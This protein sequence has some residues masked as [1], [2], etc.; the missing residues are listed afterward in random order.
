MLSLWSLTCGAESG[1]LRDGP[2]A[3]LELRVPFSLSKQ[4][5]IGRSFDAWMVSGRSRRC[6]SPI[7]FLWRS[8]ASKERSIKV[9]IYH[10]ATGLSSPRFTVNTTPLIAANPQ[11]PGEGASLRRRNRLH[12]MRFPDSRRRV[13][14]NDGE[15]PLQFFSDDAA[16][17]E[18][19]EKIIKE[20]YRRVRFSSNDR[21]V[22]ASDQQRGQLLGIL[23]S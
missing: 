9:I 2:K 16:A 4:A 15:I 19:R 17:N 10:S 12:Q 1:Q 20:F 22:P 23:C 5:T 6:A 13:A 3:R 7:A 14:S 21:S 11:F 18:E 8:R